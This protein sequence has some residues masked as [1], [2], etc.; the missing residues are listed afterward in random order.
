MLQQTR[1]L[2]VVPFYERFLARFPDVA[3]LARAE[4]DAVLGVWAGLGYYSRAR[5][6]QRAA[7]VVVE[8]HGGRLPESASALRALPGIGRYTAGAVASIAFD[9]PEPGLPGKARW[10]AMQTG[11]NL[12]EVIT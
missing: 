2:T 3:S 8:E 11:E 12:W 5:N 4:P 9:R 10:Y 6:L 7:R 1:A